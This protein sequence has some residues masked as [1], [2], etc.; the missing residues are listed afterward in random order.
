MG[1]GPHAGGDDQGH[2]RK[3]PGP[4]P[5]QGAKQVMPRSDQP[6]RIGRH[7]PQAQHQNIAFAPGCG[8]HRRHQHAG[9]PEH[10]PISIALQHGHDPKTGPGPQ[11]HAGPHSAADAGL[12]NGAHLEVGQTARQQ[13]QRQPQQQL[14][15]QPSQAGGKNAKQ[16]QLHARPKTQPCGGNHQPQ[17]PQAIFGSDDRPGQGQ[18]GPDG[19]Q[20]PGIGPGLV[21]LANKSQ[22]SPQGQG[23]Q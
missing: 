8:H 20:L 21:G 1:T 4:G 3:R 19:K 14:R 12:C 6:Q 23:R 9:Q 15:P 5:V 7:Q 13:P 2:Q 22:Q 10:G 18:H 11:R 17:R 16:I